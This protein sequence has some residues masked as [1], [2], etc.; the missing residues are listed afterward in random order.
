MAKYTKLENDMYV[1]YDR[2]SR[3]TRMIVKSELVSEVAAMETALVTLPSIDRAFKI[4]WFDAN[5]ANIDIG[6][7]YIS[8]VEQIKS[9]GAENDLKIPI[10]S[11]NVKVAWFDAN[12]SAISEAASYDQLKN[13]LNKQKAILDKLV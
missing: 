1:E 11:A 4:T 13:E 5:M 3:E 2:V 8:L 6:K 7:T 10:I 12:R 9:I